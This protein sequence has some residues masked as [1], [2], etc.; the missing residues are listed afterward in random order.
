MKK[1]GVVFIML[2][3]IAAWAQERNSAAFQQDY[4]YS[5]EKISAAVKIDGELNES[6]WTSL[7]RAENFWLK[8]PNDEGR[9]KRKTSISMAFDDKFIYFGIT[10]YDSG[11]AFIQSLKR[12]NGH[13]GND[14]VGIIIDPANQHGNGFFFVINAFNTQSE[15]Q[16]P[17]SNDNNGAAWTWDNTWLSATKRYEDKWTAEV[18]IPFKTLRYSVDKLIWGINFLRV[19][20]KSNE[21]S[22]WTHVPVNFATHSLLYTGALHWKT[23]PPSAGGNSIFIPYITGGLS[24]QNE[25][26][27]PIKSTANTGF[28]AKLALNSSLNLDLTANPDFSQIEV[29]RQVTN[30]TRFSIFFPERRTFFLENADLFSAHGYPDIRPFYSRTIGLDKDGNKVPIIAGA[31]LTGNIDKSTRIGVMTMQTAKTINTASQNYA[32]ATLNKRVLKNSILR[33]YF[34]N[35]ENFISPEEKKK[36]PLNAYGRNAGIKFNYIDLEGN[37]RHGWVTINHLKRM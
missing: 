17:F 34:L 9:P 16:L 29:D 5:L 24:K 30:L 32:A 1:I 10:A 2:Q 4:H 7:P 23:P 33:A 37:G 12:D 13:D 3:S 31:R 14:C 25:N 36:N 19:D 20:T 22:V 27:N 6:M 21:Y 26:D 28:D 8:Y 18:A 11:K 15:D 35:H